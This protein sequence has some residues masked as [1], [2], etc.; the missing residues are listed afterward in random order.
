MDD[1]C[2]KS[3]GSHDVARPG[4]HL[5]QDG[6]NKLAS[7]DL[8][9]EWCKDCAEGR[10]DMNCPWCKADGVTVDLPQAA[11]EHLVVT[12]D[13][14]NELHVHGPLEKPGIVADLAGAALRRVGVGFQERTA[15]GPRTVPAASSRLEIWI[16]GYPSFVGG[17]DSELDHN[18]DLWRAAGIEVNLVP[19]FGWDPEMRRLCD[20]RGCRTH[21]Y[22]PGVF[23]GKVLA[24]W[25]N[26]EFLK[27]LPDIM[28]KGKPSRIIWFNC[29][30][31]TFEAELE[32]HRNRWIDLFGF[33]SEYQK[34]CLLPKLEVIHPVN[35]F[36]GYKPYFN[37][38]SASQGIRFDYPRPREYF[39]VGRV[40]RDDA[41]KFPADM[42]Q[43][44]AKVVAPVPVKAFVLG[45]GPNADSRTGPAPPG[46]DWQTWARGGIPAPY[47]YGRLHCLIHKTGG[48]RE[49]YCRSLVEAMAGGRPRR[50]SSVTTRSPNLWRMELPDGCVPLRMR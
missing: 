12:L 41:N 36:E 1:G 25:C 31:W 5:F 28:E 35:V 14:R 13:C 15:A 4:S 40:S 19:M 42:W 47:L 27:A 18:I 9:F 44:F 22:H 26:G 8:V 37:P 30:T 39:A 46:L 21:E 16:G 33:V 3:V 45:Y 17:A 43:I 49:S 11:T 10:K 6:P 50:S 2:D 38:M 24:S 29:M 32:A 34:G 23:K 7:P 48:S 20:A